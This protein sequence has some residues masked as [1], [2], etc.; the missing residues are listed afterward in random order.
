[1][2]WGSFIC[3]RWGPSSGYTRHFYKKNFFGTSS[4]ELIKENFSLRINGVMENL[5]TSSF[6]MS[7]YS[8]NFIVSLV[9]GAYARDSYIKTMCISPTLYRIVGYIGKNSKQ[10][11][12]SIWDFDVGRMK[13]MRLRLC[14]LLEVLFYNMGRNFLGSL[15]FI[16]QLSDRFFTWF[17]IW[18][19]YC[20]I[21]F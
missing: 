21:Q 5:R 20:L 13:N 11:I 2:G 10:N 12:F 19:W 4:I 14:S 17:V 6:T 15:L 7:M 3:G 1:M 8:Q 18:F 16:S 9:H